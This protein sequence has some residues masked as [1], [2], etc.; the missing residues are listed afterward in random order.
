MSTVLRVGSASKGQASLPAEQ[1]FDPQIALIQELI[2]LGLQAVE[3]VL[4]REVRALAG[5]RYAR[6]D[7][8]PHR[9]RWGRQPGSIYLADQYVP[10]QV[11]PQAV[12]NYPGECLRWFERP[13][14]SQ[15]PRTAQSSGVG[16]DKEHGQVRQ[17]KGDMDW[18]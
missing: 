7:G 12:S 3:E 16:A 18:T 5:P 10:I 14:F 1:D 9:V 8:A 4:Q 17:E 6:G 11:R 2:P 15:E 13:M